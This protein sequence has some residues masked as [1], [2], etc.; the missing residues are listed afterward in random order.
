[1]PRGRHSS[2]LPADLA[3]RYEERLT[4]PQLTSLRAE[5][6]LIDTRVAALLASDEGLAAG[7]L[8]RQARKQLTQLRDA[9][10][11]VAAARRALQALD[12][13]IAEGQA[14]AS[15]WADVQQLLDLRRK[16]VEAEVRREKQARPAGAAP[17]SRSDVAARFD[18]LRRNWPRT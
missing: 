12:D 4:D 8:W 5:L 1:M 2:V 17:R 16:L 15:R 3:E 10:A 14:A 18:D 11:N 9:K 6:A 13:T 7:P